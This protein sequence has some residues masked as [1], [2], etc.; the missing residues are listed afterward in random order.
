[1]H[2]DPPSP[3]LHKP[4]HI[5][6]QSGVVN[7]VGFVAVVDGSVG[8]ED[9]VDSVVHPDNPDVCLF[10]ESVARGGFCVVFSVSSK[11]ISEVSS[12][13]CAVLSVLADADVLAFVEGSS[14]IDELNSDVVS[15]I[16]EA[17]VDSSVSDETVFVK[18]KIVVAVG[19]DWSVV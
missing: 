13:D 16:G 15:K 10:V 3:I 7:A 4:L 6:L 19:S 9:S 2:N 12:I 1:M 11:F 17:V 5:S 14:N 18:I 8:V